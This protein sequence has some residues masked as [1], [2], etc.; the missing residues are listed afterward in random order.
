L[1]SQQNY[2]ILMSQLEG[3]ESRIRTERNRYNEMV[4]DYNVRVRRFPGNMMAG[5]FGFTQ[6]PSFEAS[7]G[8]EN[9][10]KV[11]FGTSDGGTA[12]TNA[13]STA[14]AQAPP[15]N[16]EPHGAVRPAPVH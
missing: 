15:A 11:N 1:K 14:P 6:Y 12:P 5:M 9:A 16:A 8:A 2:T 3:Q 4:R 10:P 13:P 7:Q